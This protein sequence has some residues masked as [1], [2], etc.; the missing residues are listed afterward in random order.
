MGYTNVHSMAGGWTA[1]Q[2][3]ELPIELPSAGVTQRSDA[4][5]TP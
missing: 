4:E 2:G 1:W 3:T 5:G